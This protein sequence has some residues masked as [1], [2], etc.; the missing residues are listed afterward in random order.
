[1]SDPAED[2]EYVVACPPHQYEANFEETACAISIVAATENALVNISTST[3]FMQIMVN[4][5][6]PYTL[7]LNSSFI[8]T[9]GHENKAILIK[10]QSQLTVVVYK[11]DLSGE[12]VFMDGTQVYSLQ[13]AG[14]EHY[15]MA[16]I[17]GC[18]DSEYYNAYY[19]LAGHW[20]GTF[21]E[22]FDEQNAFLEA[23]VLNQYQVYTVR[24]NDINTDFTGRYMRSLYPLTAMAGCLCVQNQLG[25]NGT[26][27]TSLPAL[28]HYGYNFTTPNMHEPI[29]GGYGIRILASDDFTL[30]T[31][32]G[33]STVLSQGE[34]YTIEF[35]YQSISTWIRCN[36]P[37]L[38]EQYTIS[39]SGRLVGNF[40]FNII[41]TEQYY[42]EAYFTTAAFIPEGVPHYISIVVQGLPPMRDIFLDGQDLNDVVTW[43]WFGEYT[44]TDME[45]T[46]GRHQLSSTGD[47]KF[48]VYVYCHTENGG[49][50]GYPIW[51]EGKHIYS[52]VVGCVMK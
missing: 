15:I 35:T 44:Y 31:W 50:F 5:F 38:V 2:Y 37:C 39:V 26:Y 43:R 27:V 6:T 17:N 51:P 33:G 13:V 9:Q 49:G 23:V 12:N 1:M 22:I 16:P 10:S 29:S 42:K 28:I 34:S 52:L 25:M 36:R 20:D 46:P 48:A 47:K 14:F 32:D 11:V 8:T 18:P 41:P 40:L 7:T 4:Q 45:I 30:I 24:T 19:A 3:N 21:V